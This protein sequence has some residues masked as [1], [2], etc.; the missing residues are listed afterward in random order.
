MDILSFPASLCEDEEISEFQTKFLKQISTIINESLYV[1]DLHKRCFHFVSDHD[2]FLSGHSS[3]DALKMG[4][5]FFSKVVHPNDLQLFIEIHRAILH[6]L[7]D[8]DNNPPDIE[9]FAFNVKFLHCGLPLMVYHK[10]TPIFLNG[11]ARMVVCHLSGSVIR[12]SGNLGIYGKDKKT[13]SSYSFAKKQWQEKKIIKLTNREK[14]ILKLARQGKCNKEIADILH[15]TE[16][17]I[18]N[19]ETILYQNLNVHAVSEAIT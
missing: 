13:Y 2:L 16:K 12:K 6:Y 14:E 9:Y 10:M 8:P 5:D 11:C 3:D 4:Y 15:V 18:R 19:I 17:T 7:S 1:I